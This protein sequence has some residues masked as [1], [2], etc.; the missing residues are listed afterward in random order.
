MN[1]LCT[2]ANLFHT[3]SFAYIDPGTGSF[4]FQMLVAAV[5]S[6]VMVFKNLRD[7]IVGGLAA[8]FGR[9]RNSQGESSSLQSV[10]VKETPEAS[11]KGL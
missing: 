2:F 9:H 11:S 5:L 8:L 6:V 10:E 3:G 1:E 4:L 7:R